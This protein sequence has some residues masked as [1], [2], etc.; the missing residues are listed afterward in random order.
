MLFFISQVY[1]PLPCNYVGPAF[2]QTSSLKPEVTVFCSRMQLNYMSDHVRELDSVVITEKESASLLLQPVSK[3]FC[4]CFKR[5]AHKNITLLNK[6]H[7]YGCTHN[8][9]K[10]GMLN[11]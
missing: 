2:P 7:P 4:F 3:Y 6:P 5:I 1:I 8:T 11:D 10:C 9:L